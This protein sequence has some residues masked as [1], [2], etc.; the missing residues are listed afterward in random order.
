VITIPLSTIETTSPA[1]TGPR[2]IK[3]NFTFIA[4]RPAGSEVGV[5]AVL[6]SARATV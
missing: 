5:T 2:G 6:K 1:V 3:Q 4:Y